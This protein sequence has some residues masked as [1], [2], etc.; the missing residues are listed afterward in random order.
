M[1]EPVVRSDADAAYM[2]PEGALIYSADSLVEHVIHQTSEAAVLMSVNDGHFAVMVTGD[3][4]VFAFQVHRHM[5]AAHTVNIDLIDRFQIPVRL[6][7]VSHHSFISY[8][9]QVFH[10]AGSGNV[11]RIMNGNHLSKMQEAFFHINIIDVNALARSVRVST[12]ICDIRFFIRHN[13]YSPHC[14]T[15]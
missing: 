9:I 1:Q 8:R 3:E 13:C 15:G 6:D 11:G 5:T 7:R 14:Y 10:I 12:G 4:E 2:R